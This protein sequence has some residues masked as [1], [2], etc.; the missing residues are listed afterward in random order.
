MNIQAQCFNEMIEDEISDTDSLKMIVEIADS[1]RKNPLNPSLAEGI[2][3]KY[4]ETR[5]TSENMD[6]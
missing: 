5:S 3:Y 6:L 1:T 2:M 4:S